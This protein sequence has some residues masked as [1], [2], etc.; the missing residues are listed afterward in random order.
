MI[1]PESLR[2]LFDDR[3]GRPWLESLPSLFDELCQQWSLT[4]DGPVF[5]GSHVSYV[6]PVLRRGEHAVLKVQWPHREC[7]HEALA[8]R[9]WDGDGAVR[10]LEHDDDRHGLLV[11][12]CVPGTTLGGAL[13]PDAAL[14]ALIDLLPRLWKPA[15]PPGLTTL[16][17]EAARWMSDLV[18][19]W[20][21]DGRPC[22]RRLVD[23]TL[24][25]LRDLP[26]SPGE[27]VIVHQDLHG[28]NV[29]GAQREPWLAID[30]KPLA[31]EREFSVAPII[32][33]PELG[34]PP[35]VLGRLDRLTGELGLDRE[36][37]R[38]WAV[39][40][41]MAWSFPTPL[42]HHHHAVVRQLLDG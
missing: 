10:L 15:P 8:L 20:E 3:T 30:P 39:A 32:R 34:D 14:A 29:L 40:Q 25:F 27:P 4:P 37:A 42:G 7:E 35:D 11:E 36:R 5:P 24:D 23:A 6:V 41:T 33:S 38:G 28:H 26:R 1:V 31:G 17:D 2:W 9:M 18:D 12:R 16:G 22:E 13:E 21:A 19:K